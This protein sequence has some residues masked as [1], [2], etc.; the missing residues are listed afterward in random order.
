MEPLR[1][2]A[3][4]GLAIA[5]LPFLG[6]FTRSVGGEVV[7]HHPD[8]LGLGIIPI[9]EVAHAFGEVQRGA[10]LGHLDRPPRPV[11]IQEDEQVGGAVARA[12]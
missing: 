9:D 3:D 11:R 12:A 2:C 7:E 5:D 8:R 1:L 6:R 10:A 4:P